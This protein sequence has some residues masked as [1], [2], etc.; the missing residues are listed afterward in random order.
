[1]SI[2]GYMIEKYNNMANA[3]TCNRLVSEAGSLGID[4]QIV[5]IHD[6]CIGQQGIFNQGRLLERRNFV[7]NRYKWGRIKHQINEITDRSYNP[8]AAY[9]RYVN[10]YEQRKSLHSAGFLV[11][12]YMLG[13]AL[14][15][16]ERIISGLG[17]PFVA[18][19]L[20]S[21]QGTEVM[22][23][24]SNADY[25]MLKDHYG[26]QK[27]W[28]YEEFITTSIGR[29]IRFYSIRG[30]VAAC[31]IRSSRGDFRANVALGAAVQPCE[32][33]PHMQLIAADIYQ[34]TGLDFLGIDLLFGEDKPYLCEINVMPGI[35]GIEKASGVNIAKRIIETIKG[36]FG[37][38]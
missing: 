14:L 36:D 28:L 23:I 20:E 22:L 15:D 33:M 10:K 25:Q 13:T 19:G 32:I 17:S 21:S 38:E 37:N 6:T 12:G 35:E 7:I 29:D 11:P 27:E 9:E 4:L 30:D 1:M 18:K 26:D 8:L 34:Q 16:Y 5:G 31:M 3:Y 2:S 24:E